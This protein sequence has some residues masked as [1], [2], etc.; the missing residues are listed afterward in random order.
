M[1]E[2]EKEIIKSIAICV[3]AVRDDFKSAP[4][5]YLRGLYDY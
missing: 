3:A 1:K 2:E 4:A 5:N